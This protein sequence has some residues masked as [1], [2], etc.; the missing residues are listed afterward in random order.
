M[1]R[2][3]I[4]GNGFDLAHGIPSKYEDFHKHLKD[5]Y[6]NADDEEIKMPNWTKGHDG[7]IIYNQNDVVSLILFLISNAEKYGSKWKDFENSLGKLDY[8]PFFDELTEVYNNGEYEDWENSTNYQ[9]AGEEL[10]DCLQQIKSLFAEWINTIDEN[11]V[12]DTKFGALINSHEDIFLTFNYTKTLELVYNAKNVYHLHG[13]KGNDLIVGHGEC[14]KNIDT[15]GEHV[16]S[17]YSISQ[18]HEFLRKN[19]EDVKKK[20]QLFFKSLPSSITN[21]FT[22]GFSFS[23]IDITYIEEICSILSTNNM[24]WY[25][26]DYH[27]IEVIEE[28]KKIIRQCGFKGSFKLYPA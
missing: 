1:S 14:E 3:F 23:K 28:Y 5:N 22:Y 6:P 25:L 11:A 18:I 7:E 21:I 19:T 12:K 10:I 13:E 9:N 24:T 16:G 2:L 27:K 20:N 4:I 8:E 15:C 17:E 26:N